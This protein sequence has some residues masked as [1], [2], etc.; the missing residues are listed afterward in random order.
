MNIVAENL[1]SLREKIRKACTEAG[2]NPDDVRLIAVSKTKPASLIRQAVEAGQ[3]DIGESYV[4]EFVEKH[5]SGE[6]SSLPVRWHFIGHLQTNKVKHIVD[7]VCMVHSIDSLKSAEELSKR[8]ARLKLTVDYLLEVNTSG[9]ATK[10]GISPDDLL[11]SA[12]SFFHLQG[13]R[14]RGL[15][16]IAAPDRERARREF[17]TLA[18]LLVELRKTAPEPGL[19]TELSMGMSQ[20]FDL[21]I[22]EGAT[23]IRIGTAIFGSR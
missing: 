16:T 3:F 18:R 12:P 5:E 15:M 21:A 9:E 17:R 20:D 11:A 1:A 10:F 23:M 19:L 6:L 2:R 14:L 22:E 8:A 7:K 13:I 4:Q